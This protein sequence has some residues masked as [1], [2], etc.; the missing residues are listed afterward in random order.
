ME[1][2]LRS[3][4]MFNSMGS[5]GS[6]GPFPMVMCAPQM[7]QQMQMPYQQ[8]MMPYNGNGMMM[9]MPSH[10]EVDETDEANEVQTERTERTESPSTEAET[11]TNQETKEVK[12]KDLGEQVG[13]KK[14]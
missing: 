6:M 13:V 3:Q 1:N 11:P 7:M 2:E 9:A 14:W 8:V 10:K 5:M 4:F 12:E